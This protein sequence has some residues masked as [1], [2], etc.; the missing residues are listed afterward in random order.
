[1]RETILIIIVVFS[2]FIFVFINKSEVTYI[3][4]Y[5]DKRNYLVRNEK[6]KYEAANLLASIMGRIHKLRN[7]LLENKD[8]YPEFKDY[9]KRLGDNLRPGHTQV[10]ETEPGSE[11]TSYSVNKGEE[12]VFCLRSK[13]DNKLHD[14]NLMM[15]VALHEISHIA[16]PEIGHTPLFKKIFAF[17]TNKASDLKMYKIVDYAEEPTEYC[18]MILSSSIV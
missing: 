18:G 3:E 10:Y 4:S 12:L 7:Y 1:M 2:I 9:I 11:Y 14:I 5:L 13:P 6:D 8:S 16:C 17:F 15:Y